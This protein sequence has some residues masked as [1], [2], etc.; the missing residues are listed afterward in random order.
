MNPADRPKL[1]IPLDTADRL[2]ELFGWGLLVTSWVLVIWHYPS[3]PEKIP[4]HY[5]AAG[6]VD[7]LGSRA[8]IVTLPL[9][10]TILF[11]ALTLLNRYPYV[12]NY[13]VAITPANAERQYKNSTRLVRYLKT[14]IPLI[15]LVILLQTIR[16]A[17]LE[18]KQLSVW[19]LP[20]LI[21]AIFGPL[22]WYMVRSFRFRK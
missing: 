3:L 21:A 5:N 11:L 20:G 13:P 22:I 9:V 1:K 19:F 7:R 6:E 10:A 8:M 4:I 15:F 2:M 12:F 14:V 17:G 16:I 18:A